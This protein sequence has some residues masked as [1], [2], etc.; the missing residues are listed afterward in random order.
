MHE[1]L[2]SLPETLEILPAHFAGSACGAGLPEGALETWFATL[3]RDGFALDPA[4]TYRGFREV[5][6]GA[7]EELAALEA[8]PR[9]L[10][11]RL[12]EA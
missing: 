5:A 11:P 2:L 4:V 1:K 12:S 6:S 7:L 8:A 9:G 10:P 3:L